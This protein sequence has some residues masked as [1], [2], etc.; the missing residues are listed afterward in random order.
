M[1]LAFV[2]VILAGLI[3]TSTL[4]WPLVLSLLYSLVLVAVLACARPLVVK[5][6]PQPPTQPASPESVRSMP[7]STPL[8]SYATVPVPSLNSHFAMSCASYRFAPEATVPCSSESC[9]DT[10]S[11]GSTG[12]TCTPLANAWIAA[13]IVA[14]LFGQLTGVPQQLCESCD[15]RV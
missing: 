5:L 14:A 7:G 13:S 8:V 2:C 12:V 6:M 9:S 3:Q 11:V 15:R 4:Y 1:M 10:I